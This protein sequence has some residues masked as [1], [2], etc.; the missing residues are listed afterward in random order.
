VA[1]FARTVY[2][3]QL[4]ASLDLVGEVADAPSVEEFTRRASDGLAGLIAA[5]GIS[6][7]EW[8]YAEHRL[9]GFHERSGYR[10][11][12]DYL[13]ELWPQCEW[14][15]RMAP[16]ERV[17]QVETMSDY[18]PLKALKRREVYDCVY[19]PIKID[20]FL[21]ITVGA[22]GQRRAVLLLDRDKGEFTHDERA[23]AQVLLTPLARLYRSVRARERLAGRVREL[24]HA[25]REMPRRTPASPQG[26][27]ELT[28]RE[29]EVLEHVAAGRTDREIAT[30]LY[31]SVRTVQ[32]HLQHAYEKLGVRTRT[33]AAML[34]FGDR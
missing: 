29:L 16:P 10:P 8:D 14:L 26:A 23:L 33:A 19:R 24:E 31:V 1:A 12:L 13:R 17:W 4:R 30:L 20:H 18:V 22:N 28:P 3:K 32:K 6:F 2:A 27:G 11:Q 7:N 5:Q 25:L 9:S 34:V 15:V 21:A